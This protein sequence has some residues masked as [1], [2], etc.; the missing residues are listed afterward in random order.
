MPEI[1]KDFFISAKIWNFLE[2][3]PYLGKYGLLFNE[4]LWKVFEQNI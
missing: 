2:T 4:I 1:F 3:C